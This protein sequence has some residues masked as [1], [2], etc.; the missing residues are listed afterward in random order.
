M[1]PIVYKIF[2]NKFAELKNTFEFVDQG[3]KLMM[4][5]QAWGLGWIGF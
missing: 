5:F 4:L 1:S 3:R 2:Q